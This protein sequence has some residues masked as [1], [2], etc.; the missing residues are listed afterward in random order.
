MYS[1]RQMIVVHRNSSKCYLH[2]HRHFYIKYKIK[3]AQKD[4]TYLVVNNNPD[5]LK[6]NDRVFYITRTK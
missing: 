3:Y 5:K 2:Y 6:I 4:N 1:K